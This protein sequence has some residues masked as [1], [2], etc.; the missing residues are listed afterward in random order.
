MTTDFNKI[1]GPQVPLVKL[2]ENVAARTFISM[3]PSVRYVLTPSR[4]NIDFYEMHVE[5]SELLFKKKWWYRRHKIIFMMIIFF[6]FCVRVDLPYHITYSIS[7]K[8]YM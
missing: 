7:T 6:I 2:K 4:G 1:R 8:K 3:A 5:A